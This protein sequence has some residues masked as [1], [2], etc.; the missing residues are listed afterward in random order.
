M[1]YRLEL[2]TAI[3]ILGACTD[4]GGETSVEPPEVA[5]AASA[6]KTGP[7]SGVATKTDDAAPDD[8]GAD[9]VETPRAPPPTELFVAAEGRC[10]YMA[11]SLVQGKAFVHYSGQPIV[12]L[13]PDGTPTASNVATTL[14]QEKDRPV[15]WDIYLPQIDQLGGKSDQLF[16]EVYESPRE[17]IRGVYRKT[18]NAWE[19]VRIFGADA[20]VDRMYNWYDG[21]LL[22]F[23]HQNGAAL[24]SREGEDRLQRGRRRSGPRA[25]ARRRRRDVDLREAQ[26]VRHALAKR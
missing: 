26:H 22:A 18:A 14:P 11:T 4:H 6:T 2:L 10:R 9:D 20:S 12:Q 5:S 8:A 16:A 15:P 21:S 24:R 7:T 23:S 3:A 19:P 1:K 25:R 13:E 17:G